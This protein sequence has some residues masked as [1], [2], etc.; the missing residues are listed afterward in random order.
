MTWLMVSLASGEV[1]CSCTIHPL[2]S[3]VNVRS[4]YMSKVCSGVLRNKGNYERGAAESQK[5]EIAHAQ[6]V[7][8]AWGGGHLARG[9]TDDHGCRGLGLGPNVCHK[10]L[11]YTTQFHTE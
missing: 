11:S 4:K 9:V 8:G 2:S 1:D 3:R 10:P 6:Q 5:Q 7:G